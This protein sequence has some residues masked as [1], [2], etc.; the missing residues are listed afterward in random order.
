MWGQCQLGEQ[1]V[2]PRM[3]TMR[4]GSGSPVGPPGLCRASSSAPQSLSIFLINPLTMEMS[5]R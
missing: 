5:V 1:V 4:F 3:G 2:S